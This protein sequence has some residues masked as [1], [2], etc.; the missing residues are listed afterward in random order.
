[1]RPTITDHYRADRVAA[2]DRKGRDRIWR[3]YAW[4]LVAECWREERQARFSWLNA[5]TFHMRPTTADEA[6]VA[7]APFWRS[8]SDDDL[9][10]LREALRRARYPGEGDESES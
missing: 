1:M 4:A 10:C 8:I 9:D 3:Q 5:A 2:A 7:Y 6:T